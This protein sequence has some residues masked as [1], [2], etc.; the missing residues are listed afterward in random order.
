MTSKT[1]AVSNIGVE[2]CWTLDGLGRMPR[3]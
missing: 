1:K 3:C 2:A